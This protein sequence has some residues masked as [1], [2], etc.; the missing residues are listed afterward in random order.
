[1]RECG[2]SVVCAAADGQLSLQGLAGSIGSLWGTPKEDTDRL[3][4]HCCLPR[5]S[6]SGGDVNDGD[7]DRR[8]LGRIN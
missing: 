2:V 7:A 8:E 5:S 6:H 3:N 4:S 1:M